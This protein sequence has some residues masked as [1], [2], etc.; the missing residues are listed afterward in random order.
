MAKQGHKAT[1]VANK[2]NAN[3][4]LKQQKSKC[5]KWTKK[6]VK[7]EQNNGRIEKIMWQKIAESVV[8][9]TS[10]GSLH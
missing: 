6:P 8:N 10:V 5:N 2:S 1:I 9:L 4:N 7:K 3:G